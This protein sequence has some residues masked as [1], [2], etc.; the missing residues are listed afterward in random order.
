MSATTDRVNAGAAVV[1]AVAAI[2]QVIIVVVSLI[3]IYEQLKGQTDQLKQQTE[4]TKAANAQ[5]LVGLDMPSNLQEIEHPEVAKLWVD[6]RKGVVPKDNEVAQ[7]QYDTLLATALTFHE[8]LY[9]QHDKHLLDE[10]IYNAWNK[11]LTKFVCGQHLEDYWNKNRGLY[12][13]TFSAHVD[14]LIQKKTA[15]GSTQCSGITSI[16]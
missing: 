14:D 16:R 12:H 5:A 2:A 10:D 9:L 1:S 8:N 11:D 3:F 7:E 6:G 13:P 4:L 15:L